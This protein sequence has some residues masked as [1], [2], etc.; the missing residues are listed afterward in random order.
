M[1]PLCFPQEATLVHDDGTITTCLPFSPERREDGQTVLDTKRIYLVLEETLR[2]IAADCLRSGSPQ[3]TQL[4]ADIFN[5]LP[6]KPVHVSE[7]LAGRAPAV[8]DQIRICLMNGGGGGLGDG[9][10]FAPALGIL[11]KRLHELTG[12]T[13][14]MDVLTMLPLRTS[15]VLGGIPHVSVKPLPISL[16]DYMAYDAYVDF[17]GM[18]LDPTFASTHMTDFVLQRMG[19]DPGSIADEEKEPFLTLLPE[20]PP[21]VQAFLAMARAAAGERPLVAII[22]K[23]SYSRSMPDDQAAALI[24]EVSENHLPVVLMDDADQAA[25]FIQ[26]F[27]LSG[28]VIDLSPASRSFAN[29]FH[30]LAGLDAIVSVDTSAVHIGAAL[31]KPTVG[32]F[33]SIDSATRIKYS[34]TVRGI[35]LNY[36]G[37]RCK[38]P[39]GLSKSRA[40]VEGQLSTG[41]RVRLECGY[42][43]DEAVDKDAILAEAMQSLREIKATDDVRVRQEQIR[44][45]MVDRLH[46]RLAP[47]WSALSAR[48]VIARLETVMDE[49]TLS[50]VQCPICGSRSQHTYEGRVEGNIRRYSCGTCQGCF[51]L[52]GRDVVSLE[53]GDESIFS[54]PLR[55]EM[56]CIGS[57]LK[58]VI[59]TQGRAIVFAGTKWRS[60]VDQW[61]SD[62]P[63]IT[64]AEWPL[65]QETSASVTTLDGSEYDAIISLGPI[66]GAAYPQ[67]TLSPML[68]ALRPGGI[69]MLLSRNRQTFEQ[70]ITNRSAECWPQA[71]WTAL[72]HRQ[73]YRHLGLEPLWV[74]T[75]PIDREA[76][77]QT[78]GTLPPLR[79]QPPSRSELV[80]QLEGSE[81]A[82]YVGNFLAHVLRS[83]V[84]YGRFLIS[85]ARKANEGSSDV[86]AK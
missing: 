39:C 19:F 59:T 11:A 68:R 79:I 56:E 58:A 61:T 40:Y 50:A 83:V 70:G 76:L 10:M 18:L 15:C 63:R 65:G 2:G 86:G 47:C 6:K 45:R 5:I 81:L 64:L 36:E 67:E 33:N 21:E 12:A 72:T 3:P 69:V 62:Y 9:I 80:I 34:P 51:A 57:I 82:G 77:R 53:I 13:A 49:A 24:L 4:S 60:A 75:T 35:Q 20:A 30:L 85:L 31:R 14:I 37:R 38:A 8:R 44:R 28:K 54:M 1:I 41:A 32:L 22:F 55:E 29:Y 78:A 46:A 73:F 43:C 84:G 17:S 48:D 42:A 16:A 7:C 71:G 25:A 52:R 66:D 27:N 74:G 23:S 26:G